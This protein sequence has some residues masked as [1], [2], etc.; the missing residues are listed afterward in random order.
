MSPRH[1]IIQ[2]LAPD[3]RIVYT[4]NDPLV[5]TH[6][7]ALL[8]STP[9]GATNYIDADARDTKLIL[10][11]ASATLDFDQ[12]IAVM[13]LGILNFIAMTT[14]RWRSYRT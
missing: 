8:T 9:E 7:R 5:L 10:D 12:P 11:A 2:K 1:R 4:D 6:A 14:K 3:T 13:L